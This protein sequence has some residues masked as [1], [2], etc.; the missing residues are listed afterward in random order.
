MLQI[1]A[2]H[3]NKLVISHQIFTAMSYKS[4]MNANCDEFGFVD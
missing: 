3:L 4:D 2:N 1:I